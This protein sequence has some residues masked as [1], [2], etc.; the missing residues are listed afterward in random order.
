MEAP[1]GEIVNLRTAWPVDHARP[2]DSIVLAVVAD[3]K[4]GFHINADQRQV[5]P[6][7]NFKPY[8]TKVK[9]SDADSGL[10]IETPSVSTGRCN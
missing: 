8:P 1:D 7:K 10:T 4:E 5:K 6:I 2:G 9:V 3:I